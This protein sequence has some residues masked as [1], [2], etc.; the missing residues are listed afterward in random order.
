MSSWLKRKLTAFEAY[1]I[2]VIFGRREDAGATVY[3]ALLQALSAVFSALTQA[4]LWLYRHRILHDQPLGCLVVVV[5]NLTVGATA[6]GV[7]WVDPRCRT[8]SAGGQRWRDGA[9]GQ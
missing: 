4:R 5:G 3:A 6:A 2:D 1:T 9:A 8:A 7:E